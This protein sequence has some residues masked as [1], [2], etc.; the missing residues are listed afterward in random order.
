MQFI[1]TL[2]VSRQDVSVNQTR[3]FSAT[4][5]K[6]GKKWS[7]HVRLMTRGCTLKYILVKNVSQKSSGENRA[8]RKAS[9]FCYTHK[10]GKLL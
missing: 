10:V 3:H 4:T 9:R 2:N 5:N 7:G 1:N 8:S 6:N